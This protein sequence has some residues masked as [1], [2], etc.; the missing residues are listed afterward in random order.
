MDD[1]ISFT[2]KLFLLMTIKTAQLHRRGGMKN[3]SLRVTVS[4]PTPSDYKGAGKP[5]VD[6]H[7]RLWDAAGWCDCLKNCDFG[8]GVFS[9]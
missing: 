8:Q 5:T 1:K 4:F 3:D 7:L 2:M 6:A 9:Y